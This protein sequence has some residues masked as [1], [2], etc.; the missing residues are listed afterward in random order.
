MEGKRGSGDILDGSRQRALWGKQEVKALKQALKDIPAAVDKNERFKRV[1]AA[2]GHHSKKDC[3]DKYRELKAEAKL[4]QATSR[5]ASRVSIGS[6]SSRDRH[7]PAQEQ[8]SSDGPASSPFKIIPQPD[9]A[10]QQD[11]FERASTTA[12]S[13]AASVGSGQLSRRGSTFSSWSSNSAEYIGQLHKRSTTSS[14]LSSV[15]SNPSEDATIGSGGKIVRESV[16]GEGELMQV[17]EVDVED[18]CLDDELLTEEEHSTAGTG[19]TKNRGPRGWEPLKSTRS[20][21]DHSGRQR[22]NQGSFSSAPADGDDDAV[23]RRGPTAVMEAEAN[24]VR[25]LVFGNASKRFN[26]AWREQGFYFC[27][28]DGL[29][30]GLVQA[31]GGPCGVLAAV[32]AFLLEALIFGD[33]AGCDWRNPKRSQLERSLTSALTSIIWRAGDGNTAFLA[34]SEGTASV[35][36]SS[37]YRPDG[38]TERLKLHRAISRSILE[39]LVRDNLSHF[40]ERKGQGA[41]LLVYSCIFSRGIEAVR[42]DMDNSFGQRSTLMA[43][44]GYASQELVNLLLLGRAHSNVFDGRRVI[45]DD[46][47]GDAKIGGKGSK[48]DDEKGGDRVVLTGV[49][50]RARVGFLTLFEAYKHVE[51][52]DRLKTPETPVW[53]VCSESH[54]SVL[55]SLDRSLV[56]S[57]LPTSAR[58]ST[59]VGGNRREDQSRLATGERTRV[60][61]G[62]GEDGAEAFDLEYYDGLGR[63]DEIIRLTVDRCHGRRDRAAPPTAEDEAN[64]A[65]VPPL[66]LVIRTKWPGAFVDWNGTDPIL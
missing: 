41:I 45:G 5:A 44:H 15:Q 46:D 32:Q 37:R 47:D 31:E 23:L 56:S 63:Q 43:S 64:G 13:I 65:L 2:V 60:D 3:Y 11:F 62:E 27:G 54:Y 35:Q 34:V 61:I 28:I 29:R 14:T 1:A 40:I 49:P 51:V 12:E 48:E 24:G 66:D 19:Q 16:H 52:G 30:Y 36:R 59:I 58:Q 50:E 10:K 55:F 8:A 4:K 9:T 25:D 21:M 38:F 17:E 57:P 7:P 6:G 42:E 39:G 18:F 20:D 53:V 22:N 33:S 26:D